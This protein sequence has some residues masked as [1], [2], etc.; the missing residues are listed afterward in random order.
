VRQFIEPHSQRCSVSAP[1]CRG[2]GNY[3]GWRHGGN[4]V[5]DFFVSR[6]RIEAHVRPSGEEHA[7]QRVDCR[8]T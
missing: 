5:G 2:V 4:D 6:G 7:Q 1:R 8:R 3:G